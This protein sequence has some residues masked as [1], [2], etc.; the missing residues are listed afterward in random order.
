[1]KTIHFTTIASDDYLFRIIVLYQSLI[2]NCKDFHLY[3]LCAGEE[4]YLIL[5]HFGWKHATLIQL[6]QIEEQSLLTAKS[7]RTHLEYCWTLKPA[8]MHYVMSTY[9]DA[10]Y[11]AHI[12]ADMCF[13]SEPYQVFLENLD[14]SLFLTEHNNSPR[15]L[16][17]NDLTGRFNTGFVGC[18]NDVT[19]FTA[20][21]WWRNRCVEWCYTTNIVEAKLF[22]DQRYV[23]RWPIMFSNHHIL[24]SPGVNTAHWNLEN[25]QVTL[26]DGKVLINNSPLICYHF[27]GLGIYNSREFNLSWLYTIPEPALRLIYIPYVEQLSKAVD[28][29]QAFNPNFTK[30]FM[31]RGQAPECHYIRV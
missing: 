9:P 12:D 10:Q 11:F 25:Y 22:G 31:I 27:S 13:Y 28:I 8:M 26:R 4:G 21:E 17:T 7:N 2:K 30:G 18:K 14:A 16:Y 15:L 20:I 6:S 5:S 29:I 3:I 19:G 23:E 1:M 24:R